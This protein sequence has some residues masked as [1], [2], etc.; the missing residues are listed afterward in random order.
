LPIIQIFQKH[1]TAC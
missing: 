1:L